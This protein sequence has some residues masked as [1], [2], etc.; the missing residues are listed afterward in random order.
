[1]AL[2]SIHFFTIGFFL[3]VIVY[4]YYHIPNRHCLHF[5]RDA[6][7]PVRL[8]ASSPVLQLPSLTHVA[9]V[10]PSKASTVVLP[11]QYCEEDKGFV[12]VADVDGRTISLVL[13]SGS[14]NL[15]IATDQCKAES[16]PS[17]SGKIGHKEGQLTKLSFASLTANTR[18][19]SR[20]VSFL[21]A[22]LSR[23]TKAISSTD[24]TSLVH[25]GQMIVHGAHHMTGTGTNILGLMPG[26]DTA[27]ESIWKSTKTSRQWGM[28]IDDKGTFGWFWI[29]K[30]PFSARMS[31]VPLSTRVH[32]LGSIFIDSIGCK[33]G[34]KSY[35]KPYVI[36]ID[37]G[38]T[39]TYFSHHFKTLFSTKPTEE[40]EFVIHPKLTLSLTPD[41]YTEHGSC[42]LHYNDT[43]W[44]T[45]VTKLPF[46]LLGIAHMQG[47]LFHSDV[48]GKRVGFGKYS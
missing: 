24:K 25:M 29:G 45:G 35:M 5:H 10:Q 42:S 38:T 8:L 28:S 13:D 46:V 22:D 21:Q 6:K 20:P 4:V 12:V 33:L 37:T 40:L 3:V 15:L 2:E 34:N 44:M 19:S 1:M 32:H 18:T 36:M 39:E 48:A 23:G 43:K 11:T 26:K 30:F 9:K 47:I 16:C 17:H 31:W 27:L 41:Q 7:S 14:P